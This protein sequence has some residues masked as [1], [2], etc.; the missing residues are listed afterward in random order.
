MVNQWNEELQIAYM[1]IKT[2][3][4]VKFHPSKTLKVLATTSNKTLCSNWFQQPYSILMKCLP[5]LRN[6]EQVTLSK[7]SMT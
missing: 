5:L 6:D 1:K 4:L 7:I 3:A 2:R